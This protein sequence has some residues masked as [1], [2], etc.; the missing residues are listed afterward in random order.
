[1][2]IAPIKLNNILCCIPARYNS[3]RLPGKPLL[4]INNKTIINLVYEKALQIKASDIIILTDDQR[5]LDEVQCFGGKCAI[6]TDKCL[7]G[8]DRIIKYLKKINHNK[9]D[10]IVN[11]QGDE[12]FI[13]SQ[14]I[15]AVIDDHIIHKPA[16][17]TLCFK[18]TNKEE[19]LSK[20]NGKVVTDNF[21]NIIYCSRNII[22]SGKKDTIIENHLYNINVG[23][24]V[25]DKNYLLNHFCQENTQNQL[26][27]DIEW[28]KIIE[29]GFKIRTIF[30]KKMER[31]VDTIEDLN[32]LKTKYSN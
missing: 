18:T 17:T 9:Y 1:M 23:I 6:I 25:Y 22:P 16:C 29:Q 26:L 28:L 19:I 32:Y 12:P 3:S 2:K 21:N 31:G 20:S 10:I 27:E 11:I 7:N 24:F 8:T 5:I 13:K 30:S 14:A 4:K 15:N